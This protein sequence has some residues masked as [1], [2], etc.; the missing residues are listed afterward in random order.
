MNNTSGS[1]FRAKKYELNYPAFLNRDLTTGDPIELDPL[2]LICDETTSATDLVEPFQLNLFPN[3]TTDVL[4]LENPS[5]LSLG[6][7]IYNSLGQLLK[8]YETQDDIISMDL[9]G[10]STG[11]VIVE[12]MN[13]TTQQK[14]IERVIVE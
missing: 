2:P 13:L 6:I 11:L 10:I 12:M 8:V 7:K 9:E 4:Y 1:T 5:A 3:P 14:S